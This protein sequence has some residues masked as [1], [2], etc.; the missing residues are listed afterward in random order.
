MW[1]GSHWHH[2]R[3]TGLLGELVVGLLIVVAARPQEAGL[4]SAFV[5]H[6]LL[7]KSG[8]FGQN[9]PRNVHRFG[10]VEVGFV[11]SD[12]HRY[13]VHFSRTFGWRSEIQLSWTHSY[14]VRFFI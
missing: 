13:G 6:R 1:Q 14:S 10:D 3:L 9:G 4:P 7:L 2:F 12:R 5:H 11:A 8:I